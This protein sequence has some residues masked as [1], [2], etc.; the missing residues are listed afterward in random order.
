MA[1]ENIGI[2]GGFN[3]SWLP[4]A[5]AAHDGDKSRLRDKANPG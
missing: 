4:R 2:W 5:W 1:P 3:L